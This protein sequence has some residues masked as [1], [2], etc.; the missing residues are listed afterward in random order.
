M[1]KVLDRADYTFVGKIGSYDPALVEVVHE[2]GVKVIKCP[3]RYAL[4]VQPQKN[5]GVRHG[6]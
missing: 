3:P 2:N 1:A 6:Y 4:G 5:V